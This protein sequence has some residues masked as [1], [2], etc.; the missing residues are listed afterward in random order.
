MKGNDFGKLKVTDLGNGSLKV[1]NLG[2]GFEI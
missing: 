2:N 1:T